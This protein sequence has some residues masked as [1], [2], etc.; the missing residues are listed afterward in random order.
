MLATII[1]DDCYPLSHAEKQLM[2]ADNAER[3]VNEAS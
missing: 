3:F 1:A 2:L